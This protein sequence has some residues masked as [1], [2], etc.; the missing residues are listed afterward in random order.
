MK[1]YL[2]V[3]LLLSACGGQI[4]EAPAPIPTPDTA[5]LSEELK[6]CRATGLIDT[7][8]QPLA[9]IES[10]LP[11]DARVVSVNGIVSQDYRP[12]RTNVVFDEAGNVVRLWCG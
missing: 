12:E 4:G 2:P 3:L 5:V 10:R 8:G 1:H 6:P 11:A 9:A 7:I